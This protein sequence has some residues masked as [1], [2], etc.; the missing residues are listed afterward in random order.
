MFNKREFIFYGTVGVC[1][2]SEISKPD[3]S[4]Q[5]RLYYYLVPKFEKDTTI[6]IPVGSDKVIMR[7]IMTRQEAEDF[8]QSWPA[9]ECKEYSNY[10]ERS[11]TYKLAL[12][13]GDCLQFASM[14]KEIS[15][16]TPARKGRTLSTSE[17]DVAKVARKLL[18]GELAVALDLPPEEV[19]DY[20]QNQSEATDAPAN[21]SISF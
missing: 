18:F 17:R 15:R 16:L 7:K 13:S 12:Q 14:I 20:I 10:R 5:D 6:Y 19:P 8:V 11:Q 2:V 9:I 4:E 3:F 1:Q 21:L